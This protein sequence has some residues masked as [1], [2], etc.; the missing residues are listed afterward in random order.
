MTPEEARVAAALPASPE[1]LEQKLSMDVGKLKL[2][3]K[4]DYLF[5]E[6]VVFPKDY[7]TIERCRLDAIAMGKAEGSKKLKA[8]VDLE[9]CMSCGVCVVTCEPEALEMHVARPPERIPQ[10][11]RT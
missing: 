4:L 3:L 11:A 9:K 7:E 1:G 8:V 2:K 6:G 10:L 5:R